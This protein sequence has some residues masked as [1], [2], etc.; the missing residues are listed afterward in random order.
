VSTTLEQFAAIAA[1]LAE[2]DRMA[3]DVLK[4]HGLSEK[5]WRELSEQYHCVITADALASDEPRL[6]EDHAASFARAQEALKPAPEMTPEGW[7][8]L[9]VQIGS[10]NAEAALAS[11]SLSSADYLRL[12]RHWAKTLGQ[13]RAAAQRY[14]AG[15]YAH[16]ANARASALSE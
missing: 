4:A 13:D 3:S 9:V 10:G 2:G 6:A 16:E 1:E 11:R 7:A 8:E 12:S 15:L 14:A 5:G